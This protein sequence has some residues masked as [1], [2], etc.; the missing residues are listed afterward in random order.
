MTDGTSPALA[1]VAARAKARAKADG[2]MLEAL[3]SAHADGASLRVLAGILRD[4][5]VKASH[6]TIG[7]WLTNSA[8][9]RRFYPED[10]D[11]F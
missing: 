4:N 2:A 3:R 8:P 10:A 1:A 7:R 5:G 9:V 11:D 6:D